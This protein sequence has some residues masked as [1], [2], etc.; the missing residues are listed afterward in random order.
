MKSLFLS[1]FLVL[2]LFAFNMCVTVPQTYK[3]LAEEIEM[4]RT[5]YHQLVL[6]ERYVK[7]QED[8]DE[9]FA[10]VSQALSVPCFQ[11]VRNHLTRCAEVPW[12]KESGVT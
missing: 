11:P 6:N 10:K 9:Y 1:L 5:V 2:N 4:E 12:V 7:Y 3:N 8:I